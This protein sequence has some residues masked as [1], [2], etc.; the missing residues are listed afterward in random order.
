LNCDNVCL[1]CGFYWKERME[2][3]C[4]DHHNEQFK[5]RKRKDFTNKNYIDFFHFPV[6]DKF[7][8]CMFFKKGTTDFIEVF[9]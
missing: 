5:I 6:M 9:K 8:T 3:M 4:E 7:D 2:C 1:N